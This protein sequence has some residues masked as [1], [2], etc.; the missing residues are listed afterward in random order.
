MTPCDLFVTC[1]IDLFYP[2]TGESAVAVLEKHGGQVN[3]RPTQEC[4]GRFALEAGY[5][6]DAIQQAISR[7]DIDKTDTPAASWDKFVTAVKALG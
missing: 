1:L 4:C 2:D 3:F 6:N 5:V 7:V